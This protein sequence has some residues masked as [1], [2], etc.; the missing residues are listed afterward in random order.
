MLTFIGNIANLAIESCALPWLVKTFT[1]KDVLSLD[2]E[3]IASIAGETP[4]LSTQREKVRGELQTLQAAL[5]ALEILTKSP[6]VRVMFASTN[7]GL[8]T[9]QDGTVSNRT[10]KRRR[11]SPSEPPRALKKCA[12]ESPN[13]HFP[14]QHRYP[15]NSSS[16]A[17]SRS[18]SR[19]GTDYRSNAPSTI[20]FTW[21]VLQRLH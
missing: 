2:E 11:A 14:S 18:D 6:R 20:G 17:F 8:D 3:K 12:P 9:R 16:N 5:R 21:Y 7:P 10:P 1:S 4:V 15:N 19:S 13:L